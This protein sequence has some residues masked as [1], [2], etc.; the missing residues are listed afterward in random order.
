V[1]TAELLTNRASEIGPVT[2]VLCVNAG[3][4]KTST[5]LRASAGR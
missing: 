2:S 5:S 3:V 4:E 1:S